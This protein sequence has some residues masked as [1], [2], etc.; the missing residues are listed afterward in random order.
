MMINI[1]K[2]YGIYSVI[3]NTVHR[4]HESVARS[5]AKE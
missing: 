2:N 5:D 1:K 4:I 3:N